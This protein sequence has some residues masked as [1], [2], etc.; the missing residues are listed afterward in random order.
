MSKPGG[1]ALPIAILLTIEGEITNLRGS[2]L[3]KYKPEGSG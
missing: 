2:G 3:E 1:A